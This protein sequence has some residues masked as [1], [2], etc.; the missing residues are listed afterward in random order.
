M[1]ESLPNKNSVLRL[2][3]S[4]L[5]VVIFA[6]S[7]HAQGNDSS[8][9]ASFIDPSMG[10]SAGVLT[11]SA[12]GSHLYVSVREPSGLPLMVSALVKLNC[13]MTGVSISRPA[14]D[15]GPVAQ[16]K[17]VPAGD[18]RIDVTAPGYKPATERTEVRQSVTTTIQ[19]VFVYLHPESEPPGLSTKP[20]VV[21]LKVM[22]EIDK[23]LNDLHR[24]RDADAL[25]HLSKASQLA[26]TN[27]DVAYLLGML[28]VDRQ[29][30]PAADDHFQ[31]AVN[32]SPANE[33]ALEGLGY[34]QL[35]DKQPAA[36]VQSLEKAL[37][38]NSTSGRAH[39]LLANAY[40]QV[41]NY[42]K[43][44]EHA[45][46]AEELSPENGPA[47]RAL[48][49]EVLAAEGD[50]DAA[51]L[52]FNAVI[53]DFPKDPSANLAK[54]GLANLSNKNS[55]T[56]AQPSGTAPTF[57]AASLPSPSVAA[58]KAWEPP[59]V[60]T[61]MPGV[62]SD[63]ACSADDVVHRASLTTNHALENLEKFVATEHI[64]HQ[65][66]NAR[67]DVAQMRERN[68][69]YMAFITHDKEGLPF[70]DE[71]RDGSASTSEFPT[72]LATVGLVSLGVS[73][74]EPG[75]ARALEFKC[76]G[77]G[78]WRGK[79]TWLVHFSQ[80]PDKKSYLRL[81]ETKTK[82][83]EVPLKGRVWVDASSYNVLHIESDLREPV[84]DLELA[85]NHL[86]I[87][88]GPVNFQNGK[89]ELWLPWSA[90]MYLQLHGKRYHHTHTL[91]NFSL[92]SVDTSDKI[93]TPKNLP[94]PDDAPDQ[95]PPSPKPN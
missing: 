66:I 26:P 92:F 37:Q 33:R 64:Q 13:P 12:A 45:Q 89:T 57:Y 91:S 82:T 70:L 30:F 75:F 58:V 59:N 9:P 42:P 28:E 73:V 14:T 7:A 79:A 72:S 11:L 49:G 83:V 69:S 43:S 54:E 76:E 24:K 77:L 21:P 35:H 25:K 51:K 17:S 53:H 32:Y 93:G 55:V 84:K 68:F 19:Q 88:Y 78:Q 71:R 87:D 6:L 22:E 63:V 5:W 15:N 85:L 48:L 27:P 86:S 65:E 4:F 8:N 18:C 95:P 39:L 31:T 46:R 36:A 16:F 60:D 23:G 47:A 1:L 3:A 81:W 2:A 74:F 10:S 29:N 90:E 38:I 67:G 44:K 94:P 20:A 40:A 61:S 52:Q 34:V 80:R 56:S 41:G 62:A 50:R